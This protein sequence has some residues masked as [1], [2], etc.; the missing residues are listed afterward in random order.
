MILH[1]DMDAFY[2]S[3]EQRDRPELRGRPVVVGADPRGRGVVSAASYEARRFGIHSAMPIGRAYRLCPTAAFLPVDMDKYARESERIMAILADFTPLVEPLSLD[4]AFLDVSGSRA[5]HGSGVDIARGIKAR[6]REEVGLAASAGVAPNKFLAK[7]ASDLEKPDGL[8]EVR[9]GQEAAFLRDLPLRRL[10]GVGPSAERELA[11]LGARTIGDLARLGRARLEARLGAS[12]AHLFELAQ[13]IDERPVVPWHDPKSIGAEE[14]FER[15]TR[16]VARLR[17][18]LLGQADRVA[19]ELRAAGLRGRTV[20]LKLRFADFHTLTRRGTGATPT[21]DGG[22]IFRRVW[23]AFARIPRPQAV[24]LIGLSVSGFDDASDPE[25]LSLL[26]RPDR[27][28]RLGRV[29]DEVRTRF[30]ARALVR[31]SLLEPGRG[32]SRPRGRQ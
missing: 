10:W 21:A 5:L 22:E 14:T 29:T 15:D 11:A 4:E 30:G 3:V 16:D 18:T 32:P 26:G 2:A 31:G 9:P 25:Q 6:I 17:A 27:S 19:A 23:A 28:E 24:R 13:G 7:I 1:V 8:V 20:T 12:G